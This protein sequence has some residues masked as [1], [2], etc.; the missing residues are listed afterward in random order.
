MKLSEYL[1]TLERGG[2]SAFARKIGAHA[3]DLSDWCSGDRSIP[4]HY[5][6][7]IE[8]ASNGSVSRIDCRPN[9][10]QVYWP[11]LAQSSTS[12]REVGND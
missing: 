10:W 12:T 5:C 4:A 2:K 11:E 8:R 3:S 7:A 1:K 9:D 6:P